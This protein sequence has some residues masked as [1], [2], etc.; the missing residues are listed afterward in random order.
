MLSL[1]IHEQIAFLRRQKGVTQ[2]QLAQ[3]LGVTNQSYRNGSPASAAPIYSF[4]LRS[5][6]IS[7][8]PPTSFWAAPNPNL[9]A[10]YI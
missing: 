10:M 8:S 7:A 6:S 3:A 4:C 2:E 1:K 9:C 5:L